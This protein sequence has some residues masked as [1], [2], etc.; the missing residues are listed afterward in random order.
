MGKRKG[1]GSKRRGKKKGEAAPEA[2]FSLEQK[3]EDSDP[4]LYARDSYSAQSVGQGRG[5]G[6]WRAG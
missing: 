1:G 2:T 6:E 3:R 5:R 4:R